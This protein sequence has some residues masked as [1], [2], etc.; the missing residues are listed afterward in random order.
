ML[1]F[2]LI[3]S[4]CVEDGSTPYFQL[5][6]YTRTEYDVAMKSRMAESTSTHEHSGELLQR[7]C[8]G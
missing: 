2:L 8:S 5:H 4:D 7:I 6:V 1:P 3:W